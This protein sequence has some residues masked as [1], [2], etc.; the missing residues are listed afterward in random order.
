MNSNKQF[1]AIDLGSSSISAMAAEM[2]ADGAL[3]ILGLESKI[4]DDVKHGIVEQRTGASSKVIELKK[5]LQNSSKIQDISM[6][7]V[8]VGAKSMK[9][10]PFSVTRFIL[11]P[12]Y[13]TNTLLEEMT[14]ECKRNFQLS[15]F[16][17]FDIIPVSY[18]LDGV[19]MDEPAGQAGSQ[20][21]GNYNVVVGNP[22]VM[23]NLGGFIDRTGLVLEY[24]PL[25]VEALSTVLLDD[26]EREDGCALIN[27][28]G[29]TTTLA[30]FSEGVM[31][32]LLV[33][34][35][36]AKNITKD[37]QEL[38]ISEANAERL[39]CLKGT[40]L[41]S[42][43]EDPIYVQIPSTLDAQ[44][45]V[46]ISTKFLA[47][48]IEARL[49]ETLQPIF[50][51]INKLSFELEAGIVITGGGSK[52]N[53]MVDY[54]NEKTNIYTRFGDH[55][56]WLADHTDEKYFDPCYA[57]LVG[58]VLLTDEYRKEHPIEETVNEPEKKPK[59][60]KKKIGEKITQ[61][62]FNFFN[63]DNKLN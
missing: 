26:K 31:Q 25:A 38:G 15:N 8:G 33:V 3:R 2:Q 21:K 36:G 4:S 35:L 61:R 52:L 57:Q 37:I 18:Y 19:C 17:V 39:K 60:P 24:S 7:S 10:M 22:L 45:P 42:L 28:G 14:E 9:L 16:A 32:Q 1:I 51:V 50:D 44:Q 12:N 6:V 55:S 63:D 40:A 48:I 23:E 62:V 46:K 29:T 54:M 11:N 34:P 53:N 41:E 56:D 43:V 20:I 30:V 5:L 47:T 59:L 58:T 13:V 27:L 49:D